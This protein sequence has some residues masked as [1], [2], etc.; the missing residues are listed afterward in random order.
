VFFFLKNKQ[1][2]SEFTEIEQQI[3]DNS[4]IVASLRIQDRNSLQPVEIMRQSILLWQTH[5]RKKVGNGVLSRHIVQPMK[6]MRFDIPQF[7]DMLSLCDVR[8]CQHFIEKTVAR[9][10]IKSPRK[11]SSKWRDTAIGTVHSIV[12]QKKLF[13]KWDS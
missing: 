13:Q 7:Q 6:N 9:C 12:S 2:M 5:G 3:I 4:Q 1:Q 10:E 8:L 11:I